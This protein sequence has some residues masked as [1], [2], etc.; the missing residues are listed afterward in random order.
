MKSDRVTVSA[1]DAASADARVLVA[2]LDAY[3]NEVY[4][5]EF[6]HLTPVEKFLEEG[7]AFFIARANGKA[8]GCAA[9]LPLGNG[10]SELKRMWV[11]PEARGQGASAI[12]IDAVEAQARARG[13]RTMVLE[14]AGEFRPAIRLYERAGYRARGPFGDY[15]DNGVSLFYEKRLDGKKS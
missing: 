7:C 15:P 13:D 10:V 8:V 1:E 12:L 6:N 2:E 11:R 14:T 4:A 5:P 9:L 3:A